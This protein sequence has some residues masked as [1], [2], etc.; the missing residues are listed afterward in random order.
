MAHTITFLPGFNAMQIENYFFHD[1]EAIKEI[2]RITNDNLVI[3]LHKISRSIEENDIPCLQHTLHSIKPVFNFIGMPV[4]EEEILGFYKL[5]LQPA[6][7]DS[8][9][10]AYAQLWP[11]L[12][13]A[14]RLIAD[15]CRLFEM[16]A[17][18]AA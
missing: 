6:A 13:H 12:L 17:A 3:D 14:S 16:Q 1:T 18:G 4:L 15:Q 5:S 9:K 2:F 11:K 10:K 7:P 8:I